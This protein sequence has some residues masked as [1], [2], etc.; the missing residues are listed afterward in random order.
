MSQLDDE[1]HKQNA[2]YEEERRKTEVEHMLEMAQKNNAAS[3]PKNPVKYEVVSGVW[4]KRV[5]RWVKP[6]DILQQQLRIATPTNS[7]Q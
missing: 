7:I 6:K 5:A 3:A 2:Q 4:A 1:R